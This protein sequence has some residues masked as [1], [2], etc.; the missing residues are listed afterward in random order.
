VNQE[1]EKMWEQWKRQT[2]INTIVNRDPGYYKELIGG[3]A[4]LPV[5]IAYYPDR[6]TAFGPSGTFCRTENTL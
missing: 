2:I 6:L 3:R 5:R 1:P 4:G